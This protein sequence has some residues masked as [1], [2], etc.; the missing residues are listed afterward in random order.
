MTPWRHG[1]RRIQGASP[2]CGF[3]TSG[4]AGASRDLTVTDN[5][6]GTITLRVAVTGMT[7]R[8]RLPDGTIAYKDVG[9]AVLA[10]VIDYGGTPTDTSDDEFVSLSVESVSGPHPNLESDFSLFCETVIPA[11]TEP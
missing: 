10:I 1:G 11:L 4:E 9:R 2:P 5:G 6:D 8:I 3:P 7:E